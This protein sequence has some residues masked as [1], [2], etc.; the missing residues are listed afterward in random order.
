MRRHLI[1]YSDVPARRTVAIR[2]PPAFNRGPRGQHVIPANSAGGPGGMQLLKKLTIDLSIA[3]ADVPLGISGTALWLERCFNQADGS[4]NATGNCQ[5]RIGDLSADQLTWY[6]GNGVFDVPYPQV[7]LT[8]SVQAGVSI[9]LVYY[10]DPGG[11]VRV[12]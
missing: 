2:R 3:R 11:K 8:N 10:Q 12:H 1:D 7:F 4:Q 6:L 5:V 9:D